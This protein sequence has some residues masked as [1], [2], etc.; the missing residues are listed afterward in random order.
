MQKEMLYLCLLIAL[1][2]AGA[3]RV[4]AVEYRART[5][6]VWRD[7]ATW[8]PRG[9]P[10]PG[11]RVLGLGRFDVAIQKASSAAQIGLG[12][13]SDALRI[14]GTGMLML[15]P[16]AKLVLAGHLNMQA[17]GAR[18][19]LEAGARL[20]FNPRIGQR[21]EL[22]QSAPNQ[23]IEFA[24]ELGRRAEIGLVSAAGGHYFFS[25][26]GYRD[27]LIMGSY[28]RIRDAFDPASRKA[29]S[30]Y[31]G[32][33]PGTSKLKASQI[34]FV[35]CGQ[36]SIL[37][38]DAGSHTEVDLQGWS[39]KSS[40]PDA[41]N[42]PAFWFDGYGGVASPVQSSDVT[43]RILRLVSDKEIYVRFVSGFDLIDWVLGANGHPGSVR[44]GNNG[45][46]ARV[47]QQLFQ[48]I[49]D[50]GGVSLLATQ[51]SDVYFYAATDNPHG[52]DTAELRGDALLRDFWFESHFSPQT[53]TGDAVL[54]NGPQRWVKEHGGNDGRPV[55]L[56]IEHSA[57][58]G[59]TT[60]LAGTSA[61]HPV[62][63]TVNNG[64]GMRFRLRNN[65]LRLPPRFNA[66]AL[67]ENG[68]TASRTGL[69]FARNLVF[70]D[71]PTQGSALGS[72][73]AAMVQ[74]VDV[75]VGVED[76]AYFNLL[77][78]TRD[79]GLGMHAAR[80]S[81]PPDVGSVVADPMFVDSGRSLASWDLS[82][83]GPGT[84]AH[85]I[86]EMAKLNDDSG[87]DPRYRV[88]KLIDYVAKGYQPENP[89][90]LDKMSVPLVGPQLRMHRVHE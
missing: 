75:F 89:R 3:L 61:A 30:M 13:T 29:W 28:G 43:K 79:E 6:G 4:E 74:N 65:L 53:D 82:L 57:S 25:S 81:S 88:A 26:P 68:T 22:Q 42:L 35:N 52:F 33:E 59:D 44:A 71:E 66:V 5:D 84:A 69:E 34:E 90:L 73:A 45:G 54:T 85:A 1:I 40:H 50:S 56:L 41:R 24:G 21:Y 37:G 63:L 60:N 72:A 87:F 47:Q 39:F 20:L 46:N 19:R 23:R 76:N 18:L 11:D 38:L 70:A 51:T 14:D 9:V 10:G 12:D 80:F 7:S 86:D 27:S 67:D 78:S 2:N 83:G 31:L 16:G 36:V 17:P 49:R 58:I 8:T 32:N 15:A 55:E 48:V 77:P 62:F 64:E